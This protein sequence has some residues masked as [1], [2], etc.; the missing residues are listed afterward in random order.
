MNNNLSQLPPKELKWIKANRCKHRH[1]YI[2]HFNCYRR[3]I[4]PFKV[5]F[6][7]LEV[8]AHTGYFWGKSWETNIIEPISYGKILSYSAKFM[9]KH[10]VTR[11]WC[12][13]KENGEKELVK[14]LWKL[15]DECDYVVG[16]NLKQF[17][18]RWIYTRMSFYKMPMP[19]GFKVIDTKTES[20]KYLY[21]P[22]HSLN[23]LAQYFGL[24]KKIEHEGFVLWKNCVAGN[25][26]AWRKMLKYNQQD[27]L[28]LEKVFNKLR[29]LNPN[30]VLLGRRET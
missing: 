7:D 23:N 27:T 9:G 19:S 25:K 28:L 24:G 26:K 4:K 20:K 11:G 2:N 3:Q 10:P 13:F 21:V 6:L 22:S 1:F 12:H 14:E 17:D 16:H 8:T 5:L 30:W 18:L 15:L 29:P